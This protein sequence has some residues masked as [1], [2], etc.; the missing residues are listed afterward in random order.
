MASD[1]FDIVI[2][3]MLEAPYKKE[4]DEQ[5]RKEVKKDY[6]NNTTSSTSNSGNGTSGSSTIGETSK[7]KRSRS[8]SRS[9]DRKRSRSRDRDQHRRRNSQSRSRDRQH[10]HRSRSWDRR[11]SESRSRD[12]RREDRV[13]Y[14]SPP[15]AT[16]HRY[17]HSKSPH[18]REKSPV[19]EP[20]DNLSPEERDARTVF[21]MQLAAR[22]RPRDLE[23]FFSA[24]GKVRDV[25]IISD[26]NSRRSKGIAYVEFCEIQSV[27][28]AIGLTGQRLLG[29]PIIVQASQ[30]EKNRLAA[31]A[32]NLQKGTGGPMRLYVGSLHFN[33]TED[34]LRGIFE[35]FGKIDNIV[36][37]KDSD[38]GRSKG[39]G[40]ITFSD[41][42]CARRALEQLN[43]FELAGRLMRVG[44][45][46]ERLD[47]GTDITFPDGDQE[48]DLGSAGGRLQLM[49]K[50]AEGSGIQLPT[51]TAAAAAAAA[52]AAALQLNGAVP[53]GA[54]NPA[55]LTALSPAL[56]LAS[57]CFQLSSLFTPQTM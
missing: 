19:R 42:E 50:L 5:Q 34:M 49:A 39:Y 40:F 24:V 41:S 33:I 13:R 18:F 27:P 43:G 23:D 26:R 56:N 36:L 1:D 47:G 48:L 54:L 14:R 9:R 31:M 3:A 52:Q 53:L 37:M 38:T 4:E 35:P 22:I 15:L 11:R 16:G 21:C 28:L 2:E 55:A 7:K 32:N 8:H 29:V 51:T 30:A 17:G 12:H 6:P 20:I 45:V 46:T 44:H 57:Q 10:R 25:R